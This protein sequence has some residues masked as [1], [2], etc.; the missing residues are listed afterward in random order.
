MAVGAWR[1]NAEMVADAAAL[2]YLAEPVLDVTY[3]RGRF[4]TCHRP[5]Q[6]T[7]CDLD[8]ARSPVGYGVD[9]TDIPFD[10]GSFATVVLDPPYKLVGTPSLEG[11]DDDYGLT[12][13]SWSSHGATADRHGLV[14]R[15]IEECSRVLAPGGHLLLKC[16]DQVNSGKVQWQTI[17]FTTH[18]RGAGLE[19]VDQLHLLSHRPQPAGRTQRHARRNYSTLL[20][21]RRPAL[22][23]AGS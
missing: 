20:V 5:A 22:R 6:L 14:C 19:L 1:N 7:A 13:H 16:Q 2:G 15:G 4:W 17:E 3:G 18:A 10:D 8:P 12:S 11:F 23:R 9:F 21:L